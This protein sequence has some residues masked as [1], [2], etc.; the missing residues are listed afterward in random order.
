[1]ICICIKSI[2]IHFN[3]KLI[4]IAS[5][6]IRDNCLFTFNLFSVDFRKQLIRFRLL[7]SKCILLI[8]PFNQLLNLLHSHRVHCSYKAWTH[9]FSPNHLFVINIQRCSPLN[10]SFKVFLFKSAVMMWQPK[11][12]LFLLS[13]ENMRGDDCEWSTRTKKWALFTF[14]I[15]ALVSMHYEWL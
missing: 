14:I 6:L 3:R 5:H 8:V 9:N 15:S 11:N 4:E 10:I 12:N 13:S 1:M 2:L 7:C